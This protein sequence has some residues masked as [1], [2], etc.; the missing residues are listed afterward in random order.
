MNKWLFL[1][2]SQVFLY[3][4]MLCPQHSVNELGQIKDHLTAENLTTLNGLSSN[5]ITCVIKDDKG[6][7]WLGTSDGLNRYDGEE[8]RVF[9]NV[10]NDNKSLRDNRIKSLF[11]DSSGKIWIGTLTGGL[12]R[13]NSSFENFDSWIEDRQDSGS[14]SANG[15]WTIC[16]DNEGLIWFGTS[17]GGLK[18]LNPVTGEVNAF[19]NNSND[20]TSLSNNYVKAIY[21]NSEGNLWI[22]TD[23]GLE[24]FDAVNKKFIRK[25][26]N[27]SG[28]IIQNNTVIVICEDKDNKDIL[29]LGTGLGLVRFDTKTDDAKLFHSQASSVTS[30]FEGTKI[31]SIAESQPGYLWI[32]T[33]SNGIHKFDKR[34]LK[35]LSP[36]NNQIFPQLSN[37]TILNL[38]KDNSEILWIS[39]Y[40]GLFKALLNSSKF[41]YLND[42]F[43]EQKLTSNYIWPMC[44]DKDG[45]IWIGTIK[46]L[47]SYDQHSGKITQYLQD[48]NN[49]SSLSNNTVISVFEDSNEDIWIGTF[50]GGLNR[51]AKSSGKFE[52]WMPIQ[53]D[54]SGLP[55]SIVGCIYEDREGILWIGTAKGLAIFNKQ[56]N[57]PIRYDAKGFN[58]KMDDQYISDIFEDSKGNFWIATLYGG[59]LLLDRKNGEFKQWLQVPGD[60]NSISSNAVTDIIELMDKSDT[61]KIYIWLGTEGGGVNKFDVQTNTFK[62]F[63][64][65]D[66]LP[67][68]IISFLLSDNDGFIWIST[69]KGLVLMDPEAESI[70]VFDERDGLASSKFTTWAGLKLQSGELY[71]GTHEGVIYF[72]PREIRKEQSGTLSPVVITSLEVFNKK[73]HIGN[74]SPLKLSIS[75]TE[76][77]TLSHKDYILSLQ[78]AMLDFIKP[79]QNRYAYKLEG[80]HEEWI[81]IGSRNRADFTGLSPGEYVFRVKAANS[82]GIWNDAGAQLRIFITPPF[83]QTWWFQTIA[84]II[85]IGAIWLLHRFRV[86]TL[87][88]VEKTR[89]RIARDLHDEVSATL[90]GITWFAQAAN[91]KDSDKDKEEKQN[92]N[93]L[94]IESATDAQEKIKDIIWAIQPENDNWNSLFAHCQRYAA[95]LFES[96]NIKPDFRID[97]PADPKIVNIEIRQNFWLIFK[98]I[99]TNVVKHSQCRKAYINL[100]V[101][102]STTNLKIR[103]DGIGFDNSLENMGNGLKNINA[104][105]KSLNATLKL[106]SAAGSGTEWEIHFPMK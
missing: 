47:N 81:D 52:H 18:V 57:K 39:T 71:F 19:K 61:S 35:Y 20:N 76:S 69:E 73:I 99:I 70:W 49:N 91:E 86:K 34:S 63:T 10:I 62:A 93:R 32:G 67:D 60:K 51:F 43:G 85:I 97:I 59:L 80:F 4:N 8:I 2:L 37:K 55:H 24:L 84:V 17:G 77:I 25:K 12:H 21:Y 100:S 5:T 104:R 31:L 94:I 78:F 87:L 36:Q 58:S 13:Y 50:S 64:T 75:K 102:N 83:W 79:E 14:I 96:N 27:F 89:T 28:S 9:K 22:G 90:S 98:E 53:D 46:G 41:K 56:L 103:D 45:R 11:K 74:D 16:E 7:L 42:E 26:F 88:H 38:Y 105:A 48:D 29:W 33:N 44:E 72:N 65:N 30:V 1:S 92:L 68:N 95:D 66:G 106:K 6:F 82:K 40:E 15:V 101:S 23:N 54:H 3:V